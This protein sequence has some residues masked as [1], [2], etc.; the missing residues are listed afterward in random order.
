[1]ASTTR[2]IS[3]QHDGAE[4]QIALFSG[5]EAAEL[6]DLLCSVFSLPKASVVGFT[7]EV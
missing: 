2:L 5:L 3:V 6:S 7:A 1:M 4:R